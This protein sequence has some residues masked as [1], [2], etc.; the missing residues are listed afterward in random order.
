MS[1]ETRKKRLMEGKVI[2]VTGAGVGIGRGI[3]I[4]MAEEGA[5]VVVT[6][7]SERGRKTLETILAAGGEGIYAP[8][9]VTKEEQ[10]KAAVELAMKTYGRLD[11][12][13]NNAG[14]QQEGEF[15]LHEVPEAD[16]DNVMNVDFKGVWRCMQHE[17]P[18][19]LEGGGGTI[20]NISSLAGLRTLTPGAST[21]RAA[22]AGVIAL[23]QAASLE[24]AHHEKG[25][26]RINVIAPGAI[27]SEA[28][29]KAQEGSGASGMLDAV[30][31]STALKRIGDPSE[32]GNACIFLSSDLSSYITGQCLTVDGG[33][34]I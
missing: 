31:A 33:V 5:K 4:R 18:A 15:L 3:A 30:V 21:Y 7:R 6:N 26:I 9:D 1:D 20:V 11:G 19:M 28:L 13:I 17:I 23:T 32:I 12:A 24:Y 8:L 10:I 29:L 14:A 22:K 2:L 16:W 27:M 25:T 34:N